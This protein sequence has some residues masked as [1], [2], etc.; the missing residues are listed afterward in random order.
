[1]GYEV[2]CMVNSMTEYPCSNTTGNDSLVDPEVYCS[3][4]IS[5]SLAWSRV[6]VVVWPLLSFL[7]PVVECHRIAVLA[8][9]CSICS[10][11]KKKSI[12]FPAKYNY[13]KGREGG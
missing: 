6:T 11:G 12:H 13:V 8:L 1:M 3:S 10:I 4:G 9:T 5:V 7:M 2:D